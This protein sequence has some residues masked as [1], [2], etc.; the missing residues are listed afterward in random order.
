MRKDRSDHDGDIGFGDVPVDAHLDRGV[1]HQSARQLTQ[2][3]RTEVP[4]AL[5]ISGSHD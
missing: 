3:F 1:R 4:R 2:P 5:K